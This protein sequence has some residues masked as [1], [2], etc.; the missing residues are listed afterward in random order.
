MGKAF[1]TIEFGKEEFG[2]DTINRSSN[3]IREAE[4]CLAVDK[5]T[6]WRVAKEFRA[7]WRAQGNRDTI[8]IQTIS[9]NPWNA[10]GLL[11]SSPKSSTSILKVSRLGDLFILQIQSEYT[12]GPISYFSVDQSGRWGQSFNQSQALFKTQITERIRFV[13]LPSLLL[14]IPFLLLFISSYLAPNVFSGLILRRAWSQAVPFFLLFLKMIPLW[15]IPSWYL[16]VMGRLKG[17]GASSPS[18]TP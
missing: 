6:P 10:A 7:Q 9:Q 15:N 8:L 11:I 12:T 18:A 13:Q 4:L 5:H 2:S 16:K 14:W 3:S 1:N 17:K